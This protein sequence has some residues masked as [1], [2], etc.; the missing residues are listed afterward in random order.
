MYRRQPSECQWARMIREVSIAVRAHPLP[1]QRRIREDNA[2]VMR[3]RRGVQPRRQRMNLSGK[4][5]SAR[6]ANTGM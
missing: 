4:V 2:Y 6:M 5:F 3:P 1:T